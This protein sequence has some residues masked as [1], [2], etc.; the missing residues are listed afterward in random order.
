MPAEA[1]AVA[2]E[3]AEWRPSAGDVTPLLE[4]ISTAATLATD[5]CYGPSIP[6][7]SGKRLDL[8]CCSAVRHPKIRKLDRVHSPEAA[9]RQGSPT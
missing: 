9:S 5:S 3:A 8:R 2:A 4:R 6:G 1:V 7:G